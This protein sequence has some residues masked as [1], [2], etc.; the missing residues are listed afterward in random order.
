MSCIRGRHVG[1]VISW[2]RHKSVFCFKNLLKVFYRS[3]ER[4]LSIFV[5]WSFL[6]VHL[7]KLCWR[8]TIILEQF[9]EGLLSENKTSWVEF[10][11]D[12]VFIFWSMI[13]HWCIT[14]MASN[15]VNLPRCEGW[16][17][18]SSQFAPDSR[19]CS[20]QKQFTVQMQ[21]IVPRRSAQ[22]L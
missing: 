5:C 16:R 6:S 12:L 19:T 10:Y 7:S 15:R 13:R 14:R 9:A 3:P 11:L 17:A 8:S 21:F 2:G 18:I 4:L 1:G 20:K 22:K